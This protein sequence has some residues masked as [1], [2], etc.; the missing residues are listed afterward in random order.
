[1]MDV[2]ARQ[3]EGHT[4]SR[5]VLATPDRQEADKRNLHTGQCTK[6]KPRGVADIKPGRVTAHED[7]HQ[8]MQG[9]QIGDED[10]ASPSRNHVAIKECRQG[11]PSD[12][13]FLDSLDPEIEGEDEKEDGNGFVIIAASNGS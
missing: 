10:I 8:G 12:G 13:T 4:E 9:Q 6:S 3:M 5:H 2:N 1:M 7:Q 11:T